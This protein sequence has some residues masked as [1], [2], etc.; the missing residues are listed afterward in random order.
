MPDPKLRSN[1]EIRTS[2][3]R[4]GDV[5]RM[6]REGIA[7]G[8]LLW[9]KRNEKDE[10]N[11]KLTEK[12]WEK[13]VQVQIVFSVVLDS[14]SEMKYLQ[15][16]GILAV[17]WMAMDATIGVMGVKRQGMKEYIMVYIP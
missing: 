17:C 1:H 9:K 16:V 12:A 10:N 11:K 8:C 13:G 3:Q 7:D 15:L 4:F 14:G 6:Y 5:A 2:Q